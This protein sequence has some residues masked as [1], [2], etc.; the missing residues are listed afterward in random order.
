[1]T[2]LKGGMA[3]LWSYCALVVLGMFSVSSVGDEGS[4]TPIAVRRPCLATSAQ[5]ETCV[6]SNVLETIILGKKPQLEGAIFL[7]ASAGVSSDT[8][9]DM[10]IFD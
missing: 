2:V 8:I 5:V 7:N 9:V 6:S 1:M 10:L 4:V 3:S